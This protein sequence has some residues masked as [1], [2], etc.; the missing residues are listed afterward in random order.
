MIVRRKSAPRFVSC[1][2]RALGVECII[3]DEHAFEIHLTEQ[4][5][6]HGSCMDLASGVAG[7]SNRHAQGS[8]VEGHLSD[9]R[10]TTTAGGLDQASQDFAITGQLVKFAIAD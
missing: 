10:L 3:L 1:Q 6:E 7:L 8:G 2:K 9:E 5:L 4:L